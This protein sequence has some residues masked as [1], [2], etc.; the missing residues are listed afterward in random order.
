[1]M[2]KLPWSKTYHRDRLIATMHLSH[3]QRSALQL[4]IDL[5]WASDTCAIPSDPAWLKPRLSVTDEEYEHSIQPVI[6][7]FWLEEGE[8][9]I[10]PE[11]RQQW[12]V[13]LASADKRQTK[14]RNA[15]DVRW[16]K[17]QLKPAP[18]AKVPASDP[19]NAQETGK[20]L[21]H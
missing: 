10:N 11:L 18:Y 2:I 20:K 17:D 14:A 16:H 5:A 19:K 6:A 21:S 1:M 9:L 4:M 13:A 3:I 12:L 7:E 8:Q 15:A